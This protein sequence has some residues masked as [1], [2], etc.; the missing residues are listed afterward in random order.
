MVADFDVFA[1]H[2]SGDESLDKDFVILRVK[3]LGLQRLDS[4]TSVKRSTR[5]R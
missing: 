4:E 3:T 2:L 1:S 5:V